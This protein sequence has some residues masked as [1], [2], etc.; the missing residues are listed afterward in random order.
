MSLG[1]VKSESSQ[2]IAVVT[3][4]QLCSSTA[5]SNSPLLST[6]TEKQTSNPSRVELKRQKEDV[7]ASNDSQHSTDTS[8]GSQVG[9]NLPIKVRGGHLRRPAGYQVIYRVTL[10]LIGCFSQSLYVKYLGSTE[11][12]QNSSHL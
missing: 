1:F 12:F 5:R 3:L 11:R 10:L 8:C 7:S 4:P 2:D 6:E 9:D